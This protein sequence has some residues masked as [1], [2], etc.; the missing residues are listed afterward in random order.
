MRDRFS[1]LPHT[2][3]SEL[4]ALEEAYLHHSD[5]AEQSGFYGG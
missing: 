1:P 5:P 2:F 3:L 4:R